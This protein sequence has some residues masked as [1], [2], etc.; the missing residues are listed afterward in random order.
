M[1][2][3][4]TTDQAQAL[5]ANGDGIVVID[6]RS[7]QA[8]RLVTEEVYMKIQVLLADDSPWTPRETGLLAGAAFSKLDDTDY[9]GYL[10]E[11]Q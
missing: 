2:I 3:E 4:L 10:G 9:S 6:P 5:A 8:Y 7:K 11:N 1:T